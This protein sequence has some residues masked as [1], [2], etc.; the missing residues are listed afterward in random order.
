MNAKHYVSLEVAKKLEKFLVS[1]LFLLTLTLCYIL[2]GIMHIVA[3]PIALYFYIRRI[4]CY[5]QWVLRFGK[6]LNLNVRWLWDER[7]KK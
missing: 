3:A 5:Y 7:Q 4:G 6:R 1:M 2:Y